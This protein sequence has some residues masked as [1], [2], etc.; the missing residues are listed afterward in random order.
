MKRVGMEVR[1]PSAGTG[2]FAR[3]V[4]TLMTGTTLANLVPVAVSPLLSRLYA[5][6]DFGLFALYT[7]LAGLLA[8]TA[9][10]RYEMAIVLP[11]DDADAFD[12]LGLSL[13]ITVGVAATC[14]ALV[15]LLHHALPAL[16]RAPSLARWIGFL[17]LGVLLLG[18]G[19]ALSNWLNR[20]RAYRRLA[21]SRMAQ[22]LA[23]AAL[24]VTFARARPGAGGLVLSALA[25]QGLALLVLAVGTS[26]SLRGAGLR[27]SPAGMRRQAARYRDFPRINAVHALV[28]NVNS[29]ATLMLL[30][31]FFGAV[32]VGHYSMVMRVLTAP[33]A[34][35]GTAVTQVFYQRAA[36]V[37]NRG[38]DLGAFVRRLLARSV[39]VALPPALVLLAAAPAL[40]TLAFG[41]RWTAAGQYARLLSPYMFFSF[42]ATPLAFVPFVVNRQ[43]QSFLV[44]LG[45]NLLFLACI[46]AGGRLGRPELMF[47]ILSLV[48]AAY[49]T[50]Y[51]AWI[52]RIA[53]APPPAEAA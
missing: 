9:T 27:L 28:D 13:A 42:L 14:A 47:T 24:A 34:L 31:V 12:L 15:A 18:G 51:I 23:T 53:S 11:A 30:S 44:S 20:K 22:A 2:S 35:I 6:S 1:G 21:T 41:S 25:G 17:P 32:V 49:F 50:G 26:A 45:G 36:E 29:S 3:S 39:L 37:R 38:G 43:W 40:F 52:L 4:L 10:G 19:Q 8:V 48:Q 16:L 33:V 5:P 7:G 46:A